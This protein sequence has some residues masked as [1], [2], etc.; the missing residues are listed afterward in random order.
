MAV[1]EQ[2]KPRI[3]MD[4]VQ[5]R[6][7]Q[8]RFMVINQDRLKR[9]HAGLRDRHRLFLDLLPLLFHINHPMLPGY[10]S[11]KAPAG[12]SDY[13]PNKRTLDAARKLSKSFT[14]QQR[15][16]RA[17]D[18]LALYMMGSSGTIAYS[19]KSDFDIWVCIRNDMDSEAREML[20][21]KAANIESWAASM[22]LEV[23]FFLMDDA[24]FRAGEMDSL[25][26][27]SSGSAQHHLLLDEFY[28]TG[29]LIAG[30]YPVWWLVPPQYEMVYEEYVSQ[31]LHKR[32]VNPK[33]VVDFGGLDK[34]PAGEFFGATLWQ[35]YKAV[36]L[37]PTS[38]R[39]RYC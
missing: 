35:L 7:V 15:S 23:H 1:V 22:S 24:A 25:S 29:L 26:S 21:Q 33:E 39:S 8:R 32:F 37:R 34:M 20:A 3:E 4:G 30:R 12:V 11:S 14:Y 17:H 27:E 31:L 19:R 2:M 38:R 6:N 5:L 9:V 36:S 18:V 13:K 10:L 16:V 28:R